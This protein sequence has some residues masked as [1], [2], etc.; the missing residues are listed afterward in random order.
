M[1]NH[2]FYGGKR[3]KRWILLGKTGKPW[4]LLRKIVIL[5]GNDW[6]IFCE[7]VFVE[8]EIKLNNWILAANSCNTCHLLQFCKQSYADG[9]YSLLV[10][11]GGLEVPFL[12]RNL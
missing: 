5:L 7:G 2:G 8:V 3:G 10:E 12:Q 1:E 6:E 4:I 9:A 11:Y